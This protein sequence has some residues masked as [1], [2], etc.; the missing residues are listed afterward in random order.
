MYKMALPQSP[1]DALHFVQ[2]V[3]VGLALSNSQSDLS[4]FAKYYSPN[5]I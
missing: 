4:S 2:C 3:G 1:V 5:V